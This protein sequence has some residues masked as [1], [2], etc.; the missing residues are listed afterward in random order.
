MVQRILCVWV[1]IQ[2]VYLLCAF[3]KLLN[4]FLIVFERFYSCRHRRIRPTVSIELDVE[5]MLGHVEEKATVIILN[6]FYF[7]FC[8]SIMV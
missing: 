7:P 3:I 2:S 5:G 6:T 1:V 4:E 8:R